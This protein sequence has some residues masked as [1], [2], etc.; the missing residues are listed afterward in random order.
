MACGAVTR[1]RTM[2]P[3]SRFGLSK[4]IQRAGSFDQCRILEAECVR[5]F[6]EHAID[7][8]IITACAAQAG[9]VPYVENLALR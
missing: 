4:R 7:E 3:A 6:N 9:R 5:C 2:A 8:E 1:N